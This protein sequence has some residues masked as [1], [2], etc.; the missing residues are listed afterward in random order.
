VN[1]SGSDTF[2]V[3]TRYSGIFNR[4]FLLAAKTIL[5]EELNS[6]IFH[7]FLA[8][9]YD[10]I[11]GFFPARQVSEKILNESS[12]RTENASIE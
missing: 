12:K 10:F 11:L 1:R 4:I 2:A 8:A 6:T 9:H 3:E 5:F 7:R